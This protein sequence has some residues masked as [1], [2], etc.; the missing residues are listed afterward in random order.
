MMDLLIKSGVRFHHRNENLSVKGLFT[1]DPTTA[2][3]ARKWIKANKT[4]IIDR[5][6]QEERLPLNQRRF[7][8]GRCGACGGTDF[9]INLSGDWICSLCHPKS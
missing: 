1:L 4:A 5:L 6:D 3:E 9:W 7:L 2:G 8:P